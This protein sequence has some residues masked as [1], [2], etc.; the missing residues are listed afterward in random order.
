MSLTELRLVPPNSWVGRRGDGHDGLVV[1]VGDGRG[2][3]PDEPTV[4]S[5]PMTD[6]GTPSTATVWPTGSRTPNSS[7]AVV[8]PEHHH[9]GPGGQVVAGDEPA[10][11]HRAPPDGQPGRIGPDHRGGPVGRC[12]PP[13][14]RLRVVVGRH[15]GDVGGHRLGGQG[16]GV[17]DGQRRGGAEPAPDARA[18]GRA[19]GRDGQQVGAERGDLRADLLL[20]ALAQSDGEDHRGDADHDAE[21]GEPGPQPMGDHGLEAG[22][23]RLQRRSSGTGRAVGRGRRRRSGRP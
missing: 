3:T 10:L 15:R 17:A 9:V 19:P 20:G 11:G 8:E 14:L 18:G 5:T 2:P 1:L 23:E 16:G 6:I 7:S 4:L 13:G 21:H 12:R 22:P